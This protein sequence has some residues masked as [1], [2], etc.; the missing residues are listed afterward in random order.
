MKINFQQMWENIRPKNLADKATGY[1]VAG[2]PAAAVGFIG[3]TIV[4]LGIMIPLSSTGDDKDD[5]EKESKEEDQ[6]S[7]DD[8]DDDDDD[9]DDDDEEEEAE[10][11][12]SKN[13]MFSFLNQ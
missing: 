9:D 1:T 13:S 5:E 8:S 2:V 4:V 12:E 7:D 6:E 11:E 3:V 10:E